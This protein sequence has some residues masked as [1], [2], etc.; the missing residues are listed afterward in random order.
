MSTKNAPSIVQQIAKAV[1]ASVV[2]VSRY[3][4]GRSSLFEWSQ[5][6]R[7]GIDV[8]V[9]PLR[10][11]IQYRRDAIHHS[12]ERQGV[13]F[14]RSSWR[15]AI[16]SRRSKVKVGGSC[17][18][19][20]FLP[21]TCSLVKH[22]ESAS[23]GGVWRRC[24]HGRR[25]TRDCAKRILDHTLDVHHGSGRAFLLLGTRSS[26]WSRNCGWWSLVLSLA[27]T[28]R[29]NVDVSVSRPEWPSLRIRLW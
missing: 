7:V 9:G 13:M 3:P 10:D 20:S 28:M 19:I 29:V 15:R 26:N 17:D 4:L 22:V 27:T 11:D 8:V 21:G 2:D 25:G 5:R 24:C 23:R 12:V 18:E 14:L 1:L 6:L 16:F